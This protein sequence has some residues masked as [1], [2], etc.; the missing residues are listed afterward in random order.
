[1]NRLWVRV[2]LAMLLV[3]V[4]T[5]LLVA[6]TAQNNT[7][8]QFDNF[9]GRQRTIAQSDLMAALSEHFEATSSWSGADVILRA[10]APDLPR[11][12]PAGPGRAGRSGRP[13]FVLADADGRVV[14]GGRDMPPGAQLT[15]AQR[16][17]AVAIQANNTTAGYLL[18]AA[19]G[20]PVMIETQR[21]FFA[22]L[23][24]ILL[25]SA[26]IA[27]LIAILLSALFSQLLTAPLAKLADAARRFSPRNLD[28]RA[29]PGG[30]RE[31][32]DVAH[33]FNSMADSLRQ[34]EQNRRNLTADI[35]HEL[36]TPLT[37]MQGNLR[38]MI[39]G[40]Y[41]LDQNEVA[42]VYAESRLL[43]RLVDDLRI[44]SLAEAGQLDLRIAD[45][46]LKTLI[47]DA[48]EQFALV[49][50]NAGS[51]LTATLGSDVDAARCD[52]DRAAQVLRNLVANAIRHTPAGGRV[53]I[54][55]RV[56]TDGFVRISVS[57]TGEGIQAEHLPHIFDRFY[58]A[59]AARARGSGGSGLG[60]AIVK[61]LVQAMG[62][63]VG[64]ESVVG[65]GTTVWFEL[66]RATPKPAR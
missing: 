8:R 3:T 20:E 63:R 38:A 42:K 37:V 18:T 44:L 64:A 52:P 57:D 35:A 65:A 5:S 28:V 48:L 55:A 45:A 59:D 21:L 19:P 17:I 53:M 27:S 36:R 54:S 66:P 7:I 10:A 14:F 23:R 62:G 6:L 2:A 31:I 9:V 56:Q 24:G 43:G 49:A 16:D 41:P 1:M 4:I 46:P 26:L 30:A 32:A 50:E 51:T 58:R 47:D 29:E 39:D 22:E 33:A 13:L 15:E 12:R 60:L 61:S 34:A 11:T 40:V 25:R